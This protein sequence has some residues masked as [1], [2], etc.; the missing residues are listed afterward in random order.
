MRDMWETRKL[1]YFIQEVMKRI[2][3]KIEARFDEWKQKMNSLKKNVKMLKINL[4]ILSKYRL[5]I[6]K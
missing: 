6:E 2:L 5:H 4:I 3:N 1:R